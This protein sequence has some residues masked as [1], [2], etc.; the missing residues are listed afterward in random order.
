VKVVFFGSG[1]FAVPALELLHGRSPR[2]PLRLAVTRPDRPAGRGRKLLPTPVRLRAAELGVACEAPDSANDPGFLDRLE[3]V[4]A[5]LFI[6]A[7]YGEMLRKRLREA[8]SI[9]TFNLHASLLP[10][11][12]GAAPVVHAL[13]A[14]EEETGVTLFRVEKGLDTGPIVG[15]ART[16]IAPLETAGEL[17]ERLARL[18]AGLL[19][20]SL[21]AFAAETFR[22]TPQD[23]RLATRA[24]KL[25]KRAGAVD[26]SL[27][28]R[29][30]VNFVRA[31]NPWP[32]AFS[33]LLGKDGR[34]E[35]TVFL[36]VK[37]AA[38]GGE[39]LPPGTVIDVRGD[40]FTVRAGGG[41]VEVLEVQREG[42]APLR[43]A[44]YLRGRPLRPG[45]VFAAGPGP[46]AS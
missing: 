21:D 32:G 1:T 15:S 28:P 8:P 43:A 25:E 20:A 46:G 18:A 42:K 31:L 44:E 2:H 40:G 16:G 37:E 36:R 38:P 24:P 23:E 45:D 30:L 33:F 27:A 12:R 26:W 14:G 35:R 10:A 9:G 4:G 17:E 11:Y 29:A 19:D 3:R 6:V 7:D 41:A 5:D 34:P 13:L 39:D 22:E